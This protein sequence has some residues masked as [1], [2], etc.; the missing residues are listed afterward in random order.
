MDRAYCNL[1]Y[2]LHV[3]S[4]SH[5]YCHHKMHVCTYVHTVKPPPKASLRIRKFEHQTEE[6]LKWREFNIQFIETQSLKLNIK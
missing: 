4:S 5:T 2:D 3:N 1:S 6:N